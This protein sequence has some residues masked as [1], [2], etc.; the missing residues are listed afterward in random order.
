MLMGS[1]TLRS[2]V[3]RLFGPSLE[4]LLRRELDDS[5]WSVLDLGSGIRP[6]A[7][8]VL[9]NPSLHVDVYTPYL[10]AIKNRSMT[11]LLDLSNG[12]DNF[13][14]SSYDVVLLLDVLEH[15]QKAAALN[16]LAEAKRI[17]RKKVIVFTSDGFLPQEVDAWGKGGDTYQRH[18]CGFVRSELEGLGLRCKSVDVRPS[19]WHDA[20]VAVFGVWSRGSKP[21]R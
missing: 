4:A 13:I 11:L 1:K 3:A 17:A 9:L 20:H 21:D 6:N 15:L 14:A 7:G 10:D 19:Q 12:L 2:I 16:L 5:S 18:R 8:V